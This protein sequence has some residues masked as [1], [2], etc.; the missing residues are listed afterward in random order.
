[1]SELKKYNRRPDATVTAVQIN[2]ALVGHQP[3]Q[4]AKWGGTQTAEAGDWLV[5]NNGDVYTIK[6]D[7]FANTYHMVSPGVYA[8]IG[9]IYEG[10]SNMQLATVAKVLIDAR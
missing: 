9:Q 6:E 8:K 1:M 7:V 2:L 5:N 10:T 4:Y 3:L